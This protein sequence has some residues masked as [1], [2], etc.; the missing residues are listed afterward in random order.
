ME[1]IGSTFQRKDVTV[2]AALRKM[3]DELEL[4]PERMQDFRRVMA[5]VEKEAL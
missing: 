2:C 1:Q 4:Y 3:A 5:V